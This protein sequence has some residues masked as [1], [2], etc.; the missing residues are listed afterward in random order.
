MQGHARTRVKQ[1]SP[2][3]DSWL[4]GPMFPTCVRRAMSLVILQA[5]GQVVLVA[6]H[7]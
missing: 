3:R 4:S 2:R 6:V 7:K 5:E 1:A